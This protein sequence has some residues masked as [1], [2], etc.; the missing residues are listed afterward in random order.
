MTKNVHHSLANS[1]HLVLLATH[2]R[3]SSNTSPP[4][5]LQR[6]NRNS[7]FIPII[8]VNLQISID[9][10]VNLNNCT[11]ITITILLLFKQN[12]IHKQD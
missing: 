4:A 11:V 5:A 1:D 12:C 6:G 9:D 2:A 8:L 3:V 7:R 10:A